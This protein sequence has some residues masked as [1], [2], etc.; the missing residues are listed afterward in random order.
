MIKRIFKLDWKSIGAVVFLMVSGLITIY[1]FSVGSGDAETDI[2]S[3]QLIFLIVG[4]VF[5]FFFSLVDYRTWLKYS[6][7]IYLLSL[8]LLFLVLFV[9]QD[10]R[11]TAGWFNLGFFNLQPVELVKFFTIIF[12]ASYLVKIGNK[13]IGWLEFLRSA[14]IMLPVVFLVMKQPDFG[15]ASVLIV[16]WLG[17]LF[18]AGLDKR[19]F[20]FFIL[21]LVLVFSLGWGTFLKDY[22]KERIMTFLDPE[23]DPLGSGYNVIQSIIAVGSGGF[24]GKGIGKGSQSQ[25][26]FL[27]EKHTDFVFA[28]ISEEF[29]LISSILIVGLFW[30]IFYRL[31]KMAR[32]S[33]DRFG[34]FVAGGVLIM[35]FY[36]VVVNIGMNIG[37]MPVT[38]ISL[39]F[40]SYGGSSLVIS[41]VC[42]GVCQNIWLKRRRLTLNEDV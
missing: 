17:M 10:I 39:P 7:F 32:K 12:L 33:R 16:I 18:I 23:R 11:G 36:Q 15:S 31:F 20:V 1:S 34:Q 29:G 28:S 6:N 14:V 9:G 38:G 30:F 42:F 41:L 8:L 27:P 19:Y 13:R 40:I 22:Q 35:F 5:F 37:I 4:L 3:K 25:L 26:D 24:T 21:V 2:F